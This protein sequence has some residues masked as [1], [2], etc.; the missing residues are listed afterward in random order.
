MFEGEP[1]MTRRWARRFALGV[2]RFGLSPEA[3]W[4]LTLAEW[5]ALC[6]GAEPPNPPPDRARLDALR[7]AYPDSTGEADRDGR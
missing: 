2:M 5:Q 3:F 6:A 7:A 4:R 1:R